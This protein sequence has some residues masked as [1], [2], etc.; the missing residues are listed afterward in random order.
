MIELVDE[1]HYLRQQ[2]KLRFPRVK[3]LRDNMTNP[4]HDVL[5]KGRISK[6]YYPILH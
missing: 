2:I 5:Q 6:E 4:L 3:M 1:N